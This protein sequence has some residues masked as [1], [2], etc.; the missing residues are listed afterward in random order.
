MDK[1][2]LIFFPLCIIFKKSKGGFYLLQRCATQI[3][4]FLYDKSELDQSKKT[5][6]Q[7]GTEL[8]LSTAAAVASIL[9]L[10]ALLGN[11]LWGVIFLVVF[12]SFRLPGGGYH[13]STYRNCFI[14]T[15][16]VFLASFILSLILLS[17]PNIIRNVLLLISC[18]AIWVLAPISNPHHPVSE[19]IFRKNKIIVRGMV[20]G[21]S[22]LVLLGEFLLTWHSLSCIYSASVVAVA[23]MMILSKVRGGT[24]NE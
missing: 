18:F 6:Y 21:G 19:R 17:T 23:T 16:S 1:T 22:F 11:L 20:S 8:T 5:I 2:I 3:V 9:L 13:A 12:I 15:N 24:K 7:Y 10:A 14:L 4:G